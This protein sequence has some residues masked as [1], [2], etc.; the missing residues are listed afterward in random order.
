V[1]EAFHTLTRFTRE[2]EMYVTKVE[3]PGGRNN[4]RL[5]I[6]LFLLLHAPARSINQMNYNLANGVSDE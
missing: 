4:R 5:K 2:A 3:N 1:A 6:P